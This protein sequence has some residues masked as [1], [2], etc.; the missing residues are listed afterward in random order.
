MW[1]RGIVVFTF[2]VYGM[3]SV[4]QFRGRVALLWRLGGNMRFPEADINMNEMKRH[5][6]S[7]SHAATATA[8][9]CRSPPIGQRVLA[10]DL[11]GAVSRGKKSPLCCAMRINGNPQDE[12]SSQHESRRVR[13]IPSTGMPWLPALEAGWRDVAKCWDASTDF[14]NETQTRSLCSPPPTHP[15]STCRSRFLGR[16]A[17]QGHSPGLPLGSHCS[18][19]GFAA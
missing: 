7:Q 16:P 8:S 6:V 18:A 5:S 9:T 2:W 1:L 19:R 4:L 10:S 14:H 13:N 3:V 17:L 12:S 11:A 15:P